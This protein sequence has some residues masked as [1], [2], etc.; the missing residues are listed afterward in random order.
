MIMNKNLLSSKL[1]VNQTETIY[2][3]IYIYTGMLIIP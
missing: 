3:H 2:I 1:I